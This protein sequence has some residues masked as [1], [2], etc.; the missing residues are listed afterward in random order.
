MNYF[1]QSEWEYLHEGNNSADENLSAITWLLFM[2]RLVCNYLVVFSVTEVTLVVSAINTAFA[3]APPLG[4][5]LGELARAAFVAA[6]SLVDLAL[7]RSGYKVPLRKNVWAGEWI[8]SPGGVVSAIGRLTNGTIEGL[9][10]NGLTYSNYMIFFFVVKA[11]LSSEAG[12]ELAERAGNLIEWNIINYQNDV[13][14]DEVKMSEALELEDRFRLSE[15]KTDFSITTTVDMRMLFLS[16]IY[17]RNFADRRGITAPA[18]MP[19]SA[20]DY[21]GY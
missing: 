4:V 3:W 5:V 12:A 20:T 9:Y 11:L 13:L 6:E 14:S 21:R 19:I 7:L 15:M 8:C 10:D 16:M 2:V 17:A 1:F 18:T